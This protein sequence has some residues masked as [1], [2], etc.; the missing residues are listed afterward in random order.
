MVRRNQ[1]AKRELNKASKAAAE[2][3][4][5]PDGEYTPP[6][7][8]DCHYKQWESSVDGL[9]TIRLQ[10]NIWRQRGQ[11]ADFVINVQRL[12]SAGWVDVERFDCC[13]GHCHVHLSNAEGTVCSIRTLDDIEDVDKA[14]VESNFLADD[15]ARTIRDEGA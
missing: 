10:F 2:S 7:R 4:D 1:Q 8:E 11:I 12:S 5:Q 3:L 15:R 14:F 9:S 6:N 13:H